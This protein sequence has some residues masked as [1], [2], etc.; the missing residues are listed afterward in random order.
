MAQLW[1]VYCESD[2]RIGLASACLMAVA[3]PVPKVYYSSQHPRYQ[4]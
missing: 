4:I 2:S 3:C 1:P